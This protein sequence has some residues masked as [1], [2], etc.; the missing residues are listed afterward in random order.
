MDRNSIFFHG[1]NDYLCLKI[2]RYSTQEN[3]L[4]LTHSFLPKS[5]KQAVW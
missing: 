4:H 1:S 5:K 3:K 2:V